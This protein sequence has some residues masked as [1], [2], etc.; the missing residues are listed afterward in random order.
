ME[1]TFEMDENVLRELRDSRAEMNRLHGDQSRRIDKLAEDLNSGFDKVRHEM[2]VQ[3]GRVGKTETDVQVLAAKFMPIQRAVYG[4][5]GL[6]GAGMVG[7]L[8]ALAFAG[9]HP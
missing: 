9:H 6:M 8:M 4:V 7:A 3:N 2:Q 5:I 1:R